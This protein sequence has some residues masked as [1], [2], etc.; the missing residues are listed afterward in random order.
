MSEDNFS[1]E[2]L[3]VVPMTK[4][5]EERMEA[6]EARLRAVVGTSDE[7]RELR[8]RQVEACREEITR[9]EA[10]VDRWISASKCKSPQGLRDVLS[11]A[12]EEL[13]SWQRVAKC[14]TPEQ[15]K[16]L[17]ESWRSATGF[18]TPAEAKQRVDALLLEN[19]QLTRRCESLQSD[20]VR[21]K[22]EAARYREYRQLLREMIK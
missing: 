18:D 21:A 12:E 9:L 3:K 1:S 8:E 19:Q 15:L 11:S 10:E 22:K 4:V 7:L 2:L 6:V 14:C 13:K 20:L 16:A 5:L 17:F